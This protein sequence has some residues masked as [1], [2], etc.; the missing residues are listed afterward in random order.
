VHGCHCPAASNMRKANRTNHLRPR[1]RFGRNY[2]FVN[3]LNQGLVNAI[4][5]R[6][7][8]PNLT[9][10]ESHQSPSGHRCTTRVQLRIMNRS[11]GFSATR[12]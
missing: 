2:P 5:P 12:S 3:G 11:A 8:P 6:L 1:K 9:P 10:A 4:L 7:L